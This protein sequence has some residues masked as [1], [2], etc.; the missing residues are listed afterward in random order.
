MDE[1]K[2]PAASAQ[3]PDLN[4]LL[5]EKRE[6]LKIL[7]G[8]FGAHGQKID[9]EFYGALSSL[10]TPEELD[11]RFDDDPQPPSPK[12]SRRKKRRSKP[13]GSARA[14]RPRSRQRTKRAGLTRKRPNS[15][16]KR[17]KSLA[18]KG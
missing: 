5:A 9:G 15:R 6:R 10:L 18:P 13:N 12:R 17:Q 14:K 11:L 7:E 8:E 1:N 2:Q 4:Q 3:K 16:R